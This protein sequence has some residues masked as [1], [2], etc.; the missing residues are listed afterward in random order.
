MLIK[1]NLKSDAL[2]PILGYIEVMKQDASAPSLAMT[3]FYLRFQAIIFGI[4]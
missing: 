4:F 1:P 2:I 3:V